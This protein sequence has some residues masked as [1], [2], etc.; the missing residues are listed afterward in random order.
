VLADLFIE[1]GPPQHIRSDNGPEFV[2][3]AVRDWLGRLGLTTLYIEPGSP[4]ENGYIERLSFARLRPNARLRDELLNGE[5]FYSLEEVRCVTG[6]RRD[7]YNGLRPHSSLGCRPP[8]PETIKMPAWPVGSAPLRLPPRLAS[9]VLQ[10]GEEPLDQVALTIEPLA[11]ARLPLA[12]VLRRDVGRGTLVLD[13]L[14]DA[15]GIVCLVGEH[16]GARA[17]LVEQPVSDPTVVRLSCRQA[18]PDREALRVDNDMD[19][20]R[21]P[22]A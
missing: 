21:E 5:I 7:H 4:W 10:L 1:H 8:A 19:L 9:E 11:E 17:E 18:E 6:W 14:A 13:Q 3:H 16:D 20:G 15:V 2:A 12:I 22:A